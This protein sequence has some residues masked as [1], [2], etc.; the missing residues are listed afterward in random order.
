M[1]SGAFENNAYGYKKLNHALTTWVVVIAVVVRDYFKP[2]MCSGVF[3]KIKKVAPRLGNL[4][5]LL[6][7]CGGGVEGYCIKPNMCQ[8]NCI[9]AQYLLCYGGII[10]NLKQ[11]PSNHVV[12]E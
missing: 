9:I 4:D 5:L 7:S 1:C 6:L 11:V 3:E 12:T 2:S 10:S 8:V